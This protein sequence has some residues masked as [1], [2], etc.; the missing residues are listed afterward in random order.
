MSSWDIDSSHATLEFSVR[1]L[2]L[3]SVKGTFHTLR[4]KVAVDEEDLTRSS[5][6]VEIEVASIDTRDERRDTHLRSAD[7][8]D[9]DNYPLA[10]FTSRQVR[11]LHDNRYEVEGDLSIRG[12]TRPVTLD[13]EVS[14]FITDPWGNRR[15]AVEVDGE[16]NRTDFGLNWNQVLEAGRL[17]VGERVKIHAATEVVLAQAV[18]A[19]RLPSCQGPGPARHSAAGPR[20]GSHRSLFR[21]W[22]PA[23]K[24][25]QGRNSRVAVR[26]RGQGRRQDA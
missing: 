13:A 25:W 23:P 7:F 22:N 10:T 24:R 5:G 1:H 8:F 14:E 21:D 16:I 11:H 3:A 4:G 19:L 2:G 18:A 9:A 17:M 12:T 15:F 20:A 26:R 6:S